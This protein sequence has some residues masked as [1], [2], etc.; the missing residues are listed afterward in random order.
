M[1]TSMLRTRVWPRIPCQ[2]LH[3]TRYNQG[4]DCKP[5]QVHITTRKVLYLPINALEC[6]AKVPAKFADGTLESFCS[7]KEKRFLDRA[8]SAISCTVVWWSKSILPVPGFT[9]MEESP[10]TRQADR[11][12]T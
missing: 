4:S 3:T 1:R 6:L 11:P 9:S 2:D 12:A 10:D 7:S 8:Y 5:A